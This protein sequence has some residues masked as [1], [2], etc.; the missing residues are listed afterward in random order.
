MP[1]VAVFHTQER[2]RRRRMGFSPS[3]MGWT[4]VAWDN[5]PGSSSWRI[6]VRGNLDPESGTTRRQWMCAAGT[7]FT[8]NAGALA[9]CILFKPQTEPLLDPLASNQAVLPLHPT[10]A[11]QNA[12][13]A[14]MTCKARTT[15]PFIGSSRSL[16]LKIHSKSITPSSHTTSNS[17]ESLTLPQHYKHRGP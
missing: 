8:G 4:F 3:R 1:R 10:A 9:V 16:S 17:G 15:S 6:Q 7:Q 13:L 5:T 12:P 2:A 14:V 11:S